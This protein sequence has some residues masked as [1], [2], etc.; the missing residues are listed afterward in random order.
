LKCTGVEDHIRVIR[1]PQ[2]VQDGGAESFVSI[3]TVHTLHS[4]S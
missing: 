1:F 3:T 2:E 4:K